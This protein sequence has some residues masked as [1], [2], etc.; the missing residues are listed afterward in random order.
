M[1]PLISFADIGAEY[2]PKGSGNVV[3]IIQSADPEAI[4]GG[5]LYASRAIKNRWMDNIKVV[6]W[7]P[8]EKTLA[9]F[10]P[11]ANKSCC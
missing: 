5:L 1:V 3:I 9:G 4:Y 8:S 2:S 7:G 11:T 6:F 10:A